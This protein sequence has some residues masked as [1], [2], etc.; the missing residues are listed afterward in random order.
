MYLPLGIG[1]FNWTLIDKQNFIIWSL[2][3]N[4]I[5]VPFLFSLMT[6]KN[7]AVRIVG[8]EISHKIV[9]LYKEQ[10]QNR[11]IWLSTL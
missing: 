7:G 8:I 9:N 3:D 6:Q 5:H 10:D 1:H 4:A 2:S 11:H